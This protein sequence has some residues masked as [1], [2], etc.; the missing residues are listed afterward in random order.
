MAR[1]GLDVMERLGD[2]WVVTE[3]SWLLPIALAKQGRLD[4]ASVLADAFAE[5]YQAMGAEGRIY[6]AVA[7][8]I[9]RRYRGRPE[10]A[11]RLAEEAAS[12]ARS[13]DS[14]L[15]RALALEHLADLLSG[16]DPSGAV[17]TLE[18]VAAIHAASGNVV[19]T[20]RVARIL[21]SLP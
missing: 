8:S 6:R 5:R 19:G 2:V 7:L 14:H 9:A 21:A 16:T 11:M 1:Q 17:E 15:L 12:V 13:T 20:E 3:W 18:E 4:E 10:E